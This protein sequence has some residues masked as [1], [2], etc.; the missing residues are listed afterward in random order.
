MRAIRRLT[1]LVVLPVL[2]AGLAGCIHV[3]DSITQYAERSDKV[4]LSAGNAKDAN[5]VTHMIDPWPRYSADRRIPADGQRMAAG[6]E[7]YR[8]VEKQLT[9]APRILPVQVQSPS[10]TSSGGGSGT[11]K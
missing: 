7:R 3:E 10:S 2:A 9:T 11:S 5:V 1:R 8:N 4:T 6:V